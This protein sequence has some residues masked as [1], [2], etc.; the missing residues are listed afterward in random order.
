MIPINLKLA[1]RFL[2]WGYMPKIASLL[3]ALF[4]FALLP[5]AAMAEEGEGPQLPVAELTFSP[6]PLDFG[7]TTVG[8]ET[9]MVAVNVHNAGSII[10]PI[11]QVKIEGPDSGDFKS[12][13][14]NCG[15]L[16]PGQDCTAWVAFMP[17]STGAKTA[18]LVVQPKEMP[19]VSAPLAGTGVAPQLTFT[20]GAYDFGIQR[21]RLAAADQRRR[22]DDPDRLDRDRRQ[23][24][25]Q[26]LDRQQ[27]LLERP[28]AA[29]GR[30][31]QRPGQL[32][33]LGHG[34][35]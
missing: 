2:R 21:I 33:P 31:L 9:A 15:W 8:T 17:G 25:E 35:L 32:Q 3:L 4:S 30:S 29:A 10:A 7:K 22:S 28:P 13:G 18:F 26:L 11:D 19:A 23:K 27:R 14:S 24:L 16:E 1:L 34:R 5:A 20:P 6:E 12:N